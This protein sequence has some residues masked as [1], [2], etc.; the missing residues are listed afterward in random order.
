MG[1]TFLV[2]YGGLRI[3]RWFDPP[4]D[5]SNRQSEIHR[6]F[7][8]VERADDILGVPFGDVERRAGLE[9]D[10][11]DAE[12]NVVP[13]NGAVLRQVLK[14]DWS[15]V[16]KAKGATHRAIAR[17]LKC[18]WKQ[19]DP[20]GNPD[21]KMR[22][23]KVNFAQWGCDW[24]GSQDLM[25]A[26]KKGKVNEDLLFPGNSSM[27]HQYEWNMIANGASACIAGT[28]NTGTVRYINLFGFYGD[29]N[30]YRCGRS[31]PAALL[32]VLGVTPSNET[33]IEMALE[34]LPPD[35]V[36]QIKKQNPEL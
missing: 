11:T 24:K 5:T 22:K 23:S 2:L 27:A 32:M 21:G 12:G 19:A 34:D 31:D 26:C 3:Y 6:S 28:E 13:S 17:L 25:I 20:C 4:L 29:R 35:L 1:G 30:M 7:V 14:K 10:G 16:M 8:T 9:E 36:K 15:T 18:V 33:K